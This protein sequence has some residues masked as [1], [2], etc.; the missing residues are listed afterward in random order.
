MF[1]CRFVG[2]IKNIDVFPALKNTKHLLHNTKSRKLHSISLS[3]PRVDD[4]GE[5]RGLG[6]RKRKRGEERKETGRG[7]RPATIPMVFH[8]AS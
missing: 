7:P 6:R 3:G 5:V 1:T 2:Q 8:Y 4:G